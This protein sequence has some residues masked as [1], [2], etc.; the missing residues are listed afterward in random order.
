MDVEVDGEAGA[1]A[2]EAG[3]GASKLYARLFRQLSAAQWR[4]T[5]RSPWC[6]GRSGLISV[7]C[8]FRRVILDDCGRR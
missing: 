6:S 7:R 1:V 4:A 3:S 2:V 8:S 5:H